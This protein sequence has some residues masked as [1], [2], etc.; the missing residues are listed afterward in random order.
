M[1]LQAHLR[2]SER[3]QC[4]SIAFVNSNQIEERLEHACLPR[5]HP[6]LL[7][8]T[9]ARGPQT[10]DSSWR[11]ERGPCALVFVIPRESPLATMPPESAMTG[12]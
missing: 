8:A 11:I 1:R 9:L 12:E 10:N 6:T 7:L 4:S 2:A 5:A 3:C